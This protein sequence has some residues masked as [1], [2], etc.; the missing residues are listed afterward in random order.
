M[1][2][3]RHAAFVSKF[4]FLRMI[5]MQRVLLNLLRILRFVRDYIVGRAAGRWNLF[6]AFLGRRISEF[7]LSRN[8]KPGTSR[9]PKPSLPKIRASSD[10][11][12]GGSGVLGEYVVAA[13]TVPRLA[14]SSAGFQE[15]AGQSASVTVPPSPTGTGASIPA[16]LSVHQPHS[17]YGGNRTASSS[18]N[19]SGRSG[20]SGQSR[21]SERLSRIVHSRELL[22]IAVDQPPRSPRGIYRQFGPGV[23]PS[24]SRGQLSRTSATNLHSHPLDADEGRSPVVRPSSSSSMHEPRRSQTNPSSTSI[25]LSIQAPSTIDLPTTLAG[26]PMAM[27]PPHSAPYSAMDPPHSTLPYPAMDPPHPTLPYPSMD[28]PHPTLPYPAMV[29]PETASQHYT[30]A[31]SATS[32]FILP[33]GRVVHLIHSDQIP[34]YYENVTM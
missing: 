10:S 20:W 25:N 34:R 29:H 31:S 17:V 18:S 15:D 7:R 4:A 26:E 23:D 12:S 27:D 2:P 9:N 11:A 30:I 33:E 1:A 5:S 22:P 3:Y 13:S 32:D 21:A 16:S 8:R 28:P 19:L 14:A 24:T 6:T